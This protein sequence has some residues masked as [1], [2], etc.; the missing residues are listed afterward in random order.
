MTNKRSTR[1]ETWWRMVTWRSTNMRHTNL[2]LSW[3]GMWLD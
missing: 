3:S 1:S 2:S